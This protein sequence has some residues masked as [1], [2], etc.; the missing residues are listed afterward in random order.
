MSIPPDLL[1]SS[2]SA[3]APLVCRELGLKCPLRVPQLFLPSRG[4]SQDPGV[5]LEDTL[6]GTQG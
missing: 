2:I 4:Q 1:G 6:A 5:L 3:R